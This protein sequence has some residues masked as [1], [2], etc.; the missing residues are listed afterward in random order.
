MRSQPLK[1]DAMTVPG[2][3][4]AAD[5]SEAIGVARRAKSVIALLL[6]L[7]LVTQLTLFFL[8]RYNV[9]PDPSASTQPSTSHLWNVMHYVSGIS[10]LL[11]IALSVLLSVVLC[12]IVHI[13]LVGRL[14]GV[15]KVTSS[16]IWSFVLLVFLFPWQ[17]FLSDASLVGETFRVPGALWTWSELTTRVHFVESWGGGNW[18]STLLSWF[19]F[20]GAPLIAVILILIIQLKSNRGVRMA[21]G[22]DEVL[23][24]MMHETL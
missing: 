15:G 22:E 1:E 8:I 5:Y 12:L 7:M 21:M 3:A 13:M 24:Q 16:L 10:L 14:I 19:R 9:I 4:T 2:L 20:A 18:A 6:L 17:L 11:G 23:N